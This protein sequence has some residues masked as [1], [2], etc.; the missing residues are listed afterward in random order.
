MNLDGII[1]HDPN[2]NKFWQDINVLEVNVLKHWM[3]IGKKEI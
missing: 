3:M 2:P 1:E